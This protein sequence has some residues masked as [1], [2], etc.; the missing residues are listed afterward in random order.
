QPDLIGVDVIGLGAG[1]VDRL[2][3]MGDKVLEFNSSDKGEP[4]D[5]LKFRN[6]R[7][8]MWWS[9]GRRFAEK[10]IQLTWPDPELRRELGSVSYQIKDGKLKAEGKEDVKKRLMRSPDLADAYIIGLHTLD[11]AVIGG[12]WLNFDAEQDAEAL[13]NANEYTGG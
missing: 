1:V 6:L 12:K 5:R 11:H 4:T 3:E 7:A 8:E 10:D 9:V 13:A 2:K